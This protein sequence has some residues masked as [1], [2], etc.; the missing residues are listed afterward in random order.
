VLVLWL[1]RGAPRP[2]PWTALLAVGAAVPAFLLP[3]DR[4]ATL[5]AAPDAFMTIPLEDVASRW[6]TDALETA[7]LLAVA[8]AVAVFV[9]IPRRAAPVLAVATGVL[10]AATS[11][12]ASREV[13]RLAEEARNRF[14]GGA[15][16]SWID[17]AAR[18][19]V[20]L[21]YDGSAYWNSVWHQVLWNERVRSVVHVPEAPVPGPLPQRAVSPRF[22]GLLFDVDG[23]PV[24]DGRIVA[25]TLMTFR[26]EAI[27]QLEQRD[28]DRAGLALWRAAGPPRLRTQT[29]GLLPNGDFTEARVIVYGCPQGRLEL[30]LLP[31]AGN[32]VELLA[33]GTTVERASLDGE[34]WNGTVHAPASADGSG[35][36][37]FVVRA[38]GLVGSTRIEFVES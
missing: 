26:G 27:A 12:V 35:S 30:T 5:A 32:A 8:A 18:E 31:K 33:D 11:V 4:F 28:L 34:F 23:R 6:G 3:I 15:D 22:D 29:I 14:F 10:L 17:A 2:Q 20:T 36:C 21:F 16:P 38:N 7:W 37:E 25:P 24:E 13:A 19:P 1:R 9:L